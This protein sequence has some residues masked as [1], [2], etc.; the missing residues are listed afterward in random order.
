MPITRPA[1]VAG[2]FYPA[3]PSELEAAVEAHLA[4]GDADGKPP[5][6]AIAPHAGYVYSGDVAGRAFAAL[7]RA[8]DQ[9][10]RVVLIGPAHHV[11]FE[12][13]AISGA[14]RFETPLGAV[15]VDAAARDRLID[16]GLV[17]QLDEPHAPEHSLETHLPFLQKVLGDFEL[18]PIVTGLAS[19][20]QV[21]QVLDEVWGAEETFISVSSDLSHFHT[22]DEA[23][24]IDARTCRAI[25]A[26]RPADI[27]RDD[28]CGRLAIQGLLISAKRRN[29]SVET[30]DLRN[31][32]DTAGPKDRVVGYGAWVVRG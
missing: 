27:G 23:R 29:L 20:E 16:A 19:A 2:R 1:A 24:D 15:A 28:A 6:A 9:I 12:G 14:D 5:K 10:R 17:E 4:C 21:A 18:V 8:S 31:S 32:G 25:E 11:G 3:D 26:M 30:L 13:L 22:Y 7:R